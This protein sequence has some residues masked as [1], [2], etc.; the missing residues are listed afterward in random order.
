M[1]IVPLGVCKHCSENLINVIRTQ[2]VGQG[3]KKKF[4]YELRETLV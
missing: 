4:I 2:G 3:G 1:T